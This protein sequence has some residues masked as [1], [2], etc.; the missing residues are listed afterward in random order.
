MH[1]LNKAYSYI[2]EAS[3]ERLKLFPGELGLSLELFESLW[4]VTHHGEL[5][6]TVAAVCQ[7]GQKEIG[8]VGY[9]GRNERDRK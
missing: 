4:L 2:F 8:A 1:H 9:R 7:E 6:V 3:V 5:E